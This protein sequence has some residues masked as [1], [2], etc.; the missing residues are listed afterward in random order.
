M[1]LLTGCQN[2]VNSVENAE[3]NMTPNVIR[4]SRFITDGF[5]KDRLALKNVTLSR[6]SEGFMR[7]Q[8][9]VV[10][11][12]TGVFSQ[13]W[14][15]MKRDNPYKIQ[16]KFDWFTKDGMAVDSI[17]ST[18]QNQTVIPGETAYLQSVAPTKECYDFKI[19]LKEANSL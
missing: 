1:L 9:E 2:T 6:T 18:W 12:R 13:M 11:I 16:Y 8:L 3:K 10:N 14:S 19:S 7:V 5:L 15:S 4:D 17:L